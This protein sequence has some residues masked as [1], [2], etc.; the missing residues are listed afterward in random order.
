MSGAPRVHSVWA[1]TGACTLL[2]E[3]RIEPAMLDES[4]ALEFVARTVV[5]SAEFQ[6][7]KP[8]RIHTTETIR[9]ADRPEMDVPNAADVV[10]CGLRFGDKNVLPGGLPGRGIRCSTFMNSL[11]SGIH[12]PRLEVG[13]EVTASLAVE[14]SVLRRMQDWPAIVCVA[15]TIYGPIARRQ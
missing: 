13:T 9:A 15:L 3:V 10:L 2:G 7:F 14:K 4:G 5:E 1:D 12:L 8:T 11:F 6:S